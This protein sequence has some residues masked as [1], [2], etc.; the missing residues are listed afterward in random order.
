MELD[1]S[2]LNKLT[3]YDSIEEKREK[4]PSQP[5]NLAVEPFKEGKAYK[6]TSKN[7]NAIESDITPLGGNR[8]LQLQANRKKQEIERK[9][10]EKQLK[11]GNYLKSST[12]QAEIIKGVLAGEDIYTLFLKAIDTIELL[13]NTTAF[14]NQVKEDIKAIY[15]RGLNIVEPLQV[16]M[17]EAER[18]LIALNRALSKE[19]EG[20]TKKRIKR[21]IEAHKSLIDDL[22]RRIDTNNN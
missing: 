15:G 7:S 4:Q 20:N 10:A 14:S 1:L 12:L 19:E 16:E 8:L 3:T 11:E 22:Q 9:N 18:R 17:K 21:A 5:S 6:Y 13:T 2:K